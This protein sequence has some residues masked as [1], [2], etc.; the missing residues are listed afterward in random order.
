MGDKVNN[1]SKEHFPDLTCFIR[2]VQHIEGNPE[3]FGKANGNCD[4]EDCSWREYCMKE[5]QKD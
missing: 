5:T 4:R 3:C 2:S 1:N